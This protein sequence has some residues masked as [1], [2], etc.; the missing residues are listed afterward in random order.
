MEDRQ[1]R[2]REAFTASFEESLRAREQDRKDVDG[3]LEQIKSHKQLSL[4]YSRDNKALLELRQQRQREIREKEM[5]QE[6]KL[7]SQ[8]SFNWQESLK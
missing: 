4:Q 5:Q 8:K 6:K 1:R 3:T 2:K 7:L